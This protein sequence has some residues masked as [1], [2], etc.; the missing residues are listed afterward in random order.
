MGWLE[1]FVI[2][3]GR[4]LDVATLTRKAESY[5]ELL[6][7]L[8]DRRLDPLKH[9]AEGYALAGVMHGFG[10]CHAHQG[11]RNQ[12][13]VEPGQSRHFGDCRDAVA[14]FAEQERQGGVQFDLRRGLRPVAELGLQTGESE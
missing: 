4:K 3:A 2:H 1:P 7:G 9:L 10:Y 8:R 14:G 11:S 13:G 12:C 5:R 6:M